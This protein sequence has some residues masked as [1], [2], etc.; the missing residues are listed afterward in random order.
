MGWNSAPGVPT[1]D[2]AA[3][4]PIFWADTSVAAIVGAAPT[5]PENQPVRVHSLAEL[6]DAFGDVTGSPLGRAVGDF[7]LNGGQVVLAVRAEDAASALAAL[8]EG[9][10]F[11][12]LVVDPS[13]L[14]ERYAE[15]HA[16]CERRRA[17]L[18]TD[19]LAGGAMPPGLGASAAVYF[20]AVVGSDGAEHPAAASVAGVYARTDAA[21]GVWRHPAG[22]AAQLVGTAGVAQRLTER[23]MAALSTRQ[24]NALRPMPDGSLVVWGARTAA[25]DPDRK[26]VAVQRL[27]LFLEESL[28]QGLQWAV[29]EPDD[30][31]L[32]KTI[33][34]DVQQFLWRLWHEGAFPGTKAEEAFFVRCDA[35]T[36]SPE[37]LA[38]GRGVCLVGVAPIRPGEFVTV[39]IPFATG[40][41]SG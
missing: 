25:S 27:L 17:F 11:Q 18:V 28:Q 33:C 7:L 21:R 2:P 16:L 32:R 34:S 3:R 35:A 8:E 40:G 6:T 36:S 30:A 22:S 14:E 23:E 19:A 9:P 29:H 39:R 4:Q 10:S 5:G 1:D 26:Y 15:A 24:V 13:L 12:L 41:A 20:P 38:E 37:E 31:E